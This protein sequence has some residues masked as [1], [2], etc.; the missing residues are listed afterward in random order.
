MNNE[1][2]DWFPSDT[3]PFHVG[4]YLCDSKHIR[5]FYRHWNGENW[6]QP[7]LMSYGED[8]KK[9]CISSKAWTINISWRGL[10]HNPKESK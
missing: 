4:V 7:F 9:D 5:N 6:S 2:T 1:L 10:K 3:V 8:M